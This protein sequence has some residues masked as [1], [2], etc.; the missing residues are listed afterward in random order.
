MGIQGYHV[1]AL[2]RGTLEEHNRRRVGPL[3]VKTSP[4]NPE[5]PLPVW[6]DQ[7]TSIDR[8]SS[9]VS[10][11]DRTHAALFQALF[12]YLVGTEQD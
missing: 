7:R 5:K 8:V 6:L 10:C 1:P 9:S 4:D 12:N 3:W 2:L 11:H